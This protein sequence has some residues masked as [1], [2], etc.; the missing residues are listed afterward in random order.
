MRESSP[1]DLILWFFIT[2]FLISIFLMGW[3]LFPFFSTIILAS[4]VT[5]VF[6]P[7]YKF[8][9][10]KDKVSPKSAALLT[11]ILIFF[12]LFIPILVFGT[13][14]SNEAYALFLLG[15]NAVF[16]GQIKELLVDSRI[17]ER[18][19]RVLSSFNLTLTAEQLN[20]SISDFGKFA[21]LF[22][23]EQAQMI[24]QNIVSFVIHF[25]FMLLIT[26]FLFMD[27]EKLIRF[28]IDLSPL[29]NDQDEKLFIKFK[30]MAGAVLIGNGLCGIIQ[31]VIGGIIFAAFGFRSAFLWGG[32][33]AFMAFLPILGIGIVFIPAVLY[34]FLAGRIYAGLFFIGIY[35]ILSFGVEYLIKP[36]MVGDRVE[37]HTLLVFLAIIGGMKL[38]GILGIIFGPLVVTGFLTLVDIYHASYQNLVEPK[39]G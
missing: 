4:V 10:Q 30:D 3:L 5:G 20:Q 38:F 28:V 6:N 12:T 11:C 19:N 39:L 21:G 14:L 34:L 15:K 29:P 1:N 22:L 33:M 25:F 23:F 17:L 2:L 9:V 26:F 8:F 37:M 7:I 31:G 13:I 35:I 16:D 36:K 18:V 24:A 27:A 32:L